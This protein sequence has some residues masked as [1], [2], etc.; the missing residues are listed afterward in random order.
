LFEVLAGKQIYTGELVSDVLAAVITREPD[1]SLL[2]AGIP[3]RLRELLEMCLRREPAQRLRDI[4]DA[5]IQIEKCLAEPQGPEVSG[6]A[7]PSAPAGLLRHTR[8]AWA[9]AG[10]ATLAALA[11]GLVHWGQP[12]SEARPVK[13]FLPPPEKTAFSNRL[14]AVSP[15]GRRVAFVTPV[16]RQARL[17]V[18]DLDSLAPGSCQAPRTPA[19]PFGRPMAASSDS[20]P[21]GN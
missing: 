15:D 1:W 17:W 6:V 10:L 8:L 5:R 16:D 19:S 18:R 20:L 21:K 13:L 12:A 9:W 2:P 3:R 4:G 14:P 7:D 11:L